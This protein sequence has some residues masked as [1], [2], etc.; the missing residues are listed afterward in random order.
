MRIFILRRN[1]AV[2]GIFFIIRRIETIDSRAGRIRQE[3][4]VAREIAQGGV[5]AAIRN[6]DA[7]VEVT[8]VRHNSDTELT[9][10]A[11]VTAASA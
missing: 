1:I 11:A 3:R 4:G 10:A 6:R 8:P 7:G 5:P 9:I 2:I